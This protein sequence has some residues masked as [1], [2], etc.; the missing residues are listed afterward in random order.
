MKK[1]DLKNIR[2]RSLTFLIPPRWRLC[3]QVSL[4]VI[5]SSLLCSLTQ[6]S[7]M[8]IYW[9]FIKGRSWLSLVVTSYWRWYGLTFTVMCRSQL[10]SKV[11]YR[12]KIYGSAE[13]VRN[14]IKVTAE[15]SLEV[16]RVPQWPLSTF[17][18]QTRRQYMFL[19]HDK[20]FSHEILALI[21][22]CALRVLS[23][24]RFWWKFYIRSYLI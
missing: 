14:T 10:P 16:I 11:T 24:L 19:P 5:L 18:G 23:S 12:H 1:E 17:Q 9:I 22:V 15:Y 20:N 8:D 2:L 7:C 13:T 6:K 3:D 21:A 4:F